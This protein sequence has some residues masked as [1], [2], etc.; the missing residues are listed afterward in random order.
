MRLPH[1]H[2]L[3]LTIVALCSID[4]LFAQ[5]AGDLK[6][7]TGDWAYKLGPNVLFG[8]HL[9]PDPTKPNHLRGY[10]LTPDDC[11]INLLNGTLLQFSHISSKSQQ[12]P[13]AS[14]DWDN[15][16]LQL[17]DPSPAHAENVPTYLV[18]PV[19][20][21]DVDVTLFPGLPELRMQRI[22]DAP[23]LASNWNSTSTYTQDDFAPD[24]EQM[25]AIVA[26]DQADRDGN[27]HISDISMQK[28]DAERR[29]QTANL[30]KRGLLHTGPD[31][32][33]AALIFQH[34][35]NPDDYLLAHVLAVIAVSKGQR[36]AVWISAATLDRYLQSIHQAQIF[37]TQYKVVNKDPSTQE[38]YNRD[39]VS[40]ALRVYMGVPDQKS[41]DKQRVQLDSQRG[42]PATTH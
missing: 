11:N 26:R 22:S 18:R 15:G 16:A 25:A 19:D 28:A 2:W 39:L 9:E 29:T 35:T 27:S 8:L 32:D 40:D 21:T 13:V 17:R 23:K 5:K 31:F 6:A 37:G 34:G 12:G 3:V 4:P 30:L 33:H 41:Q 38:P 1:G 20:I 42:I 36:G 24:N 7:L 14:L 10:V